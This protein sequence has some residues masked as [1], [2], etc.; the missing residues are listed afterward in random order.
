MIRV[1]CIVIGITA[2]LCAAP[3]DS[4]ATQA[5]SLAGEWIGRFNLASEPGLLRISVGGTAREGWTAT[6]VLQPITMLS[7]VG[8]ET[9]RIADSWRNARVAIDGTSW[10]V[11]AGAVP[12]AISV[13]VRT[14]GDA[15]TAKV[16][17]RNQTASVL[18]HHLVTIDRSLERQYAG[19]YVL[20]SGHRVY[21]WRPSNSGPAF[22]GV[23]RSD[24]FLNYLEE[25]SGRSGTLY[26]VGRN[27]YVAGPTSV[28]PDPVRVRAAFRDDTDGRR[29]LVW[30]ET[31]HKEVIATESKAYRREEVQVPGPAGALGCDV[32][33]PVRAGK[34]PA[35]VLVPGAGA[36]ERH[37]VY[38]MAQVFA[39]HGVAALACDKRGTG[40]SEGDWRPT[41]FEQQAQ[42]VAAG[43]RFLQQRTDIDANR[44]GVWGFSEGA[45]VAPLAFTGNPRPAFLILAAVP[46]TS[47]RQGILETNVDRLRGEGTSAPEIK[48]FREFFERY[49][50]AIMDNDAP[51]IE[52]LWRQYSGA[53]WLP[54]NM[55]TAQTLNSDWQRPRLTW[56]YEPGPVLS[57]I[58]CPVLAMWGGE[59]EQFPS[60]I[61]RPL[62]DQS[63]RAARNPDYTLRVIPG[64]DH[65]FRL[66]AR[67]FVEQTGY[68]PQYLPTV[69]EWLRTRVVK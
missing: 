59:D 7:S 15:S 38:L 40:T 21:V 66:V 57:T 61:H 32:L 10:S 29:R 20:P 24:G 13:D 42:D 5:G 36:Q 18:L 62:V 48:R 56:P 25:T 33:T 44:V 9:R 49:Q 34:N 12:D 54:A 69:V 43:I 28:L 27:S 4:G 11:A 68:A 17:F 51:E 37:E 60:G 46:A 53:S 3:G 39:E 16:S 19:V 67:S 1:A 64:A 58:T 23:A 26:P 52:R 65:S 30:Q 41:S 6:V 55:P 47:R 8:A 45:W 31:G 63:M 2:V 14:T 35:A 50:Q 22:A